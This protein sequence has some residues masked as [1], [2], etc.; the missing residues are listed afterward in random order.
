M[1]NKVE[2]KQQMC[3]EVLP[4]VNQSTFIIAGFRVAAH[5]C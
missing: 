1:G 5:G 3:T 4:N 2:L